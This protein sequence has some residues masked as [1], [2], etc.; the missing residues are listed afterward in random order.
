MSSQKQNIIEVNG[1]RYDARTGKL[2]TTPAKPV[3]SK[4]LA[5]GM[6]LDG[7][8]HKSIKHVQRPVSVTA[9]HIHASPEKSK[10]LM[11]SVVKKPLPKAIHAKAP[12][13]SP[14]APT[15]SLAPASRAVFMPVSPRRVLRAQ[16]VSQSSL[17]SKFPQEKSL[18][19]RKPIHLPIRPEPTGF[20]LPAKA[21]ATETG[22]KDIFH[23]AMAGAGSHKQAKTKKPGVHHRVAKRLNVSTRLVNAGAAT[24]AVVLIAGFFAYQNVP[25]L[26]MRV[27]SARAG[28]QAG[29]PTYQPS[30]Y[31][32]KG[33]IQYS[34]GQIVITYGSRSDDREFKLTQRTTSWND[35]NLINSFVAV[36]R[37]PYQTYQDNGKV[38]YIYEGSNATWIDKGVWYQIDGSSVL[39]SDQLLRMAASL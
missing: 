38:I 14:V 24:L 27:A 25:N 6:A 2:I 22:H 30:G 1:K 17:I 26:A 5:P 7:F 16:H 10:T 29:L 13:T 18:A 39:S 21:Q 33:A 3:S 34:P 15:R 32:V 35:E 19:A 36:D 4:K 31:G 9:H 37:R 28:V 12:A 8:N 11:R 23:R 20:D